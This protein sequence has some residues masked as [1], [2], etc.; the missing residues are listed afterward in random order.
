MSHLTAIKSLPVSSGA[1]QDRGHMVGLGLRP[2][3]HLSDHLT[4]SQRVAAVDRGPVLTHAAL[5]GQTRDSQQYWD[6]P[7][8]APPP[9]HPDLVPLPDAHPHGEGG[10]WQQR[11]AQAFPKLVGQTQ[12]QAARHQSSQHT[13]T[14]GEIAG[15]NA[16]KLLLLL[17]KPQQLR[18]LVH[19]HVVMSPQTSNRP[20]LQPPPVCV[21]VVM[22]VVV[23]P[24]PGC[25]STGSVAARAL[26]HVSLSW[27]AATKP[28]TSFS[29][30]GAL[31]V[32]SS[33][34]K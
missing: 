9:T 2:S 12:V 25:V 23:L 1:F 13:C 17:Q 14:R 16:L 10:S 22:V 18:C 26:F 19:I 7:P 4:H 8:S 3:L 5:L 6:T 11:Q 20:L 24:R 29:S 27:L 28:P 31:L 30:S 21:M 33:G 34:L 15:L 32:E